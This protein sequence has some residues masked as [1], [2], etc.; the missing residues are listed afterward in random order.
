M[1]GYFNFGFSNSFRK[2]SARF[3]AYKNQ[4]DENKSD[5]DWNSDSVDRNSLA[6][7]DTDL[8]SD[9]FLSDLEK[10]SGERKEDDHKTDES[11]AGYSEMQWAGAL[12]RTQGNQDPTRKGETELGLPAVVLTKHQDLSKNGTNFLR[13]CS[14]PVAIPETMED[15]VFC[16]Y[17]TSS[18]N[19]PK[20]GDTAGKSQLES[21]TRSSCC[22]LS[23]LDSC[24]LAGWCSLAITIIS[25]ITPYWLSSRENEKSTLI[26]LGL[27]EVCFTQFPVEHM[28]M[29]YEGCYPLKS[30]EIQDFRRLIFPSWFSGVVTTLLVS[31]CLSIISRAISSLIC[32]KKRQIFPL[33]LGFRFLVLSA[34]FDLITGLLLV[35]VAVLFAVSVWVHSWLATTWTFLS[36]SWAAD[37]LASW[38]HLA[39]FGLQLLQVKREKKRKCQKETFL[40]TMEDPPLFGRSNS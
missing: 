16:N 37:F 35:T 27:W 20:P 23:G 31:L 39:T 30:P 7:I 32:F 24:V 3:L 26:R 36:W 28:N 4:G 14:Q 13:S 5:S 40:R 2:T 38:C 1:D 10:D 18:K 6:E 19:N 21:F 25:M 29:T 17:S 34:I 15:G 33:R 22:R 9:S 12:H 8:D 11:K